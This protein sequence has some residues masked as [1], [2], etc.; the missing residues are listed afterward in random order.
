MKGPN[1][2][3]WHSQ[4]IGSTRLNTPSYE[5]SRS[6]DR[7]QSAAEFICLGE[8]WLKQWTG[9]AL[10]WPNKITFLQRVF[11]LSRV[12]IVCMLSRFQV[13][14]GIVYFKPD[15]SFETHVMIKKFTWSK[16]LKIIRYPC[17][18]WMWWTIQISNCSQKP[19]R[20]R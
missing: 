4:K 19:I 1:K 18:T 16:I 12:C 8:I 17:S 20:V 11:I 5:C 15:D 9:K 3:K 10:T 2:I 14:R 6:D 13:G 7:S